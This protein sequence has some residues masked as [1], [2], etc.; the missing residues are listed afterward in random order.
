MKRIK[1]LEDKADN[2]LL[3]IEDQGNRQLDLIDEINNKNRSIG[4]NN[5]KT[6]R[7]LEREI[8][9]K[10]LEIRKTRKLKKMIVMKK[11]KKKRK[12]LFLIIKRQMVQKFSLMIIQNY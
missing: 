5:N 7:K 4:F 10:E 6:L 8:K 11:K 3:A 2:Q 1:N 12:N 9:D